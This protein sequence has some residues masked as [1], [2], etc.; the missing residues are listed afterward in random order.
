M[1]LYCWDVGVLIC[2]F[3]GTFTVEMFEETL[4]TNQE[5]VTHEYRQLTD[6][7]HMHI[8]RNGFDHCMHSVSHFH[9]L[10]HSH[11]TVHQPG[12]FSQLVHSVCT[13]C[14]MSTLLHHQRRYLH[15]C[16]HDH[17]LGH[18]VDHRK[19]LHTVHTE[20]AICVQLREQNT[21]RQKE[22]FLNFRAQRYVTGNN[23]WQLQNISV[24]RAF[25]N[26]TQPKV[27]STHAYTLNA[28]IK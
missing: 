2:L 22:C 8:A 20:R 4:C 9:K 18:Q 19:L 28:L 16:P 6:K 5:P 26:C 17:Y 11:S 21:W 14:H 12:M 7:C 27:L 24:T 25:I 10:V 23:Q 15:W 3:D 1:Y 13:Q